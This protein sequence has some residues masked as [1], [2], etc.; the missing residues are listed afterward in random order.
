MKFLFICATS[1]VINNVLT[2]SLKDFH[3]FPQSFRGNV[4]TVPCIRQ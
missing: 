3:V 2:F 4:S 1:K